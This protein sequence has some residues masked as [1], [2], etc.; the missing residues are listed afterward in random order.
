M[1]KLYFIVLSM[2]L[3]VS[4]FATDFPPLD[5]ENA[6][7]AVFLDIK[8]AKGKDDYDDNLRLVNFT[9]EDGISFSVYAYSKR[10]KTWHFAGKGILKDIF[11]T[12][13]LDEEPVAE[14]VENY[15]YFAVIPESKGNFT[16]E[17]ERK[18]VRF[19]ITKEYLNINVYSD[20][21]I[22]FDSKNAY[23]F[24]NSSISGSFR[25]VV[26][27]ESKVTDKDIGF[28]FYASNDNEKWTIIGKSFLKEFD[29]TDMLK[30]YYEGK[31]IASYKYFSIVSL[32]GKNYKYDIKKANNDLLI[33][34]N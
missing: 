6:D 26:R 19:F 29:D 10:K 13:V 3:A 33:T 32:N 17:L 1:K 12:Y 27:F 34:I 28:K 23:T 22:K 20:K 31:Q 18:S 8:S 11:D 25:D 15:I 21:E 16:F 24:E 2:F 30:T 7:K 9:E 5:V 4:V 14:N